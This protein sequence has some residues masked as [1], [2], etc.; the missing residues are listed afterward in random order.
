MFV[1]AVWECAGSSL[2]RRLGPA[3]RVRPAQRD[4][5]TRLGWTLVEVGPRLASAPRTAVTVS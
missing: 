1:Q 4:L 3:D 5:H 2:V